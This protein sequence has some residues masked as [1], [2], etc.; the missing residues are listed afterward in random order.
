MQRSAAIGDL[1]QARH[2][3]LL[4]EQPQH[5]VAECLV[6]V[7]EHAHGACRV[8]YGRLVALAP[9]ALS[10]AFGGRGQQAVA[11]AEAADDRLY[12]HARK[13]SHVVERDLGRS[14]P[15]ELDGGVEDA[16]GGGGSSL[17]PGDHPVWA[18]SGDP[19]GFHVRDANTK[20]GGAPC[21]ES[22]APYRVG[23]LSPL[24]RSGGAD[25]AVADRRTPALAP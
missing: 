10:L 20:S 2:S 21:C 22:A 24:P 25:R 19:R 5:A 7:E 17:C 18:G 4:G 8:A 11:A 15:E 6:V 1:A 12:A 23:A 16:V 3:V 13:P 9:H 14:L